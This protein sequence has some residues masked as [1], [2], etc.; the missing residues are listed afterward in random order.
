[1]A[2]VSV[3]EAFQRRRTEATTSDWRE[4]R[5]FVVQ[6][7]NINDGCYVASRAPGVPQYGDTFFVVN[8][9]NDPTF[10]CIELLTQ[11]LD[12]D[13]YTFGVQATYSNNPL[14]KQSPLDIPYTLRGGSSAFK[15]PLYV[16][17]NNKP[18]VNSAGDPFSPPITTDNYTD[19]IELVKNV[20]DVNLSLWDQYRG[21]VNSD[22][23]LGVAPGKLKAE[24]V[25]YASRS[26]P[27]GINYYQATFRFLGKA[28]GWQRKIVDQGYRVSTGGKVHAPV[29]ANGNPPS[30]PILLDGS[31]NAL[32]PGGTPVLLD[33]QDYPTLAFGSLCPFVYTDP[34]P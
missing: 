16:D 26:A 21:A 3:L 22:T 23:F 2:V 8:G 13:G 32:A 18:V 4:V 10:H 24:A 15:V 11:P 28:A 7:N 25:T 19:Q 6:T 9:P 12:E 14:Y 33:F 17:Q 20:P 30:G 31:G 29:D 5:Y 1:M 27:Q 34:F